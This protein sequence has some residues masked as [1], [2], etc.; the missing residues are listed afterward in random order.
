MKVFID[1]F[2]QNTCMV[3][4]KKLSKFSVPFSIEQ[5]W[6]YEQNEYKCLDKKE[7]ILT[8]LCKKCEKIIEDDTW[9]AFSSKQA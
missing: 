3:C 7:V 8:S 1:D 9:D 2:T 6:N 5:Y 4:G